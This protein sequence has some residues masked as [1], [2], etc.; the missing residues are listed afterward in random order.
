MTDTTTKTKT[1]VTTADGEDTPYILG[2]R[3]RADCCGAEALVK[4]DLPNAPASLL[5][6][7]HHYSRHKSSL[8]N[9]TMILD[10]SGKLLASNN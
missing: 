9:G 3:D 7:S 4:V 5:F 2:P 6:C 1:V 10:E 8:P